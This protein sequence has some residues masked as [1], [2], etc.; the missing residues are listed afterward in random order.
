MKDQEIYS[1]WTNFITDSK[2][3]DYFKSYEEVWKETFPKLIKFIDNNKKTPS[4]HS[5]NED[6]KGKEPGI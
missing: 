5:K 3:S 6:E 4:N 1:V 2:Y